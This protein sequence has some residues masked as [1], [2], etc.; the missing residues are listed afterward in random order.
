AEKGVTKD[1]L[2]RALKPLQSNLKE[3]LRD[4]SYWLNTVLGASQEKP[5]L[6]D[7]ARTRDS[8]Y[9][10][11]TVEELNAL[12]KEFLKKDNALLYELVPKES[13]KKE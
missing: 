10:G 9:G 5:H 8:D 12:A 4:N 2:E 7:W 3:S 13:A 1:E 11:V 6:L